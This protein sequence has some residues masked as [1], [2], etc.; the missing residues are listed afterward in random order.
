MQSVFAKNLLMGIK[1]EGIHTA[2][3][4][5]GF[6]KW[7]DFEMVLDYTDLFLF[8]VKHGLSEKHQ[9]GTG[10]ENGLILENLARLSATSKDIIVRIPLIPGFNMSQ[11]EL[12]QTGEMLKKAGIKR[13]EIIPYHRLGKA[14]YEALGRSYLMEGVLPPSPEEVQRLVEYM[15]KNLNIVVGGVEQ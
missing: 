13:I 11:S 4:T 8:D 15:K 9:E 3:E 2:I 7:K 6:V 12:L 5:S 10:A 14:K 1:Q